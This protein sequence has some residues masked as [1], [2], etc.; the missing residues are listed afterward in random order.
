M[1]IRFDRATEDR[2]E[3]LAEQT[4]RSKSYYIRE[5]V[6]E[7]LEEYEDYLIA[8]SRLEERGERVTLEE[9]EQELELSS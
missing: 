5:A 9:L 7:Y 6:R 2:L 3:K 8:L 1:A 4:G